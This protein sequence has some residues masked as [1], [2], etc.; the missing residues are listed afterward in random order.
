MIVDEMKRSVMVRGDFNT[1]V[2]EGK[3]VLND[4]IIVMKMNESGE[5]LIECTEFPDPSAT[6]EMMRI[7]SG[8]Q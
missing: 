1:T 2:V 5:K 3:T 8:G 4:L 6:A 7:W